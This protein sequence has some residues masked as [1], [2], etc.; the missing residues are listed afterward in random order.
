MPSS[1]G[2]TST[3]A[4]RQ[5]FHAFAQ[6]WMTAQDWKDTTRE[7]VPPAI[8]RIGRVLPTDATLA[9]VG[10]L[11]IKRARAEL[12]KGYAAKTVTLSMTYLLAIM[13][14]A[15]H[16]GRIPRDVPGPCRTLLP[17]P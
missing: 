6:E 8:A 10:Q 17:T 13:R 9:S 11:A 12:S 14:T 16:A 4:W 3:R 2:R 7:G 5:S 15:Y 1:P